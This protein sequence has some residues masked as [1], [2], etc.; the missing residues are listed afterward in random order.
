MR[1]LFLTHYFFP[2][3]NAPA[4]R[5]YEM[6]RRWASEGHQ[7]TVITGVPNVPDGVVYSGY[8]NG[9]MQR[10]RVEG[11][12]VIR[13]W[14]YLAPNKGTLRRILNYVSF[15]LTALRA[16]LFARRPYRG[17][18]IALRLGRREPDPP[19]REPDPPGR[20]RLRGEPAVQLRELL[21]KGPNV[22][23]D[24]EVRVRI[25]VGKVVGGRSRGSSPTTSS[26]NCLNFLKPTT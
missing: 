11:V 26:V 1:I 10:E 7:V 5:V 6:T 17:S 18:S 15:M 22:V 25:H 9:W 12:D 20:R 23:D 13:V 3:G 14:T 24:H 16:G 8:R 2:E 21:G 19:E 4:T